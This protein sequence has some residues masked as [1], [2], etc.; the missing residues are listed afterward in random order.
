MAAFGARNR[1][2]EATLSDRKA[3][4]TACRY[5]KAAFGAPKPETRAEAGMPQRNA[6][7]PIFGLD[8]STHTL[9]SVAKRVASS[10][11]VPRESHGQRLDTDRDVLYTLV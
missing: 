1:A 11:D 3:A 7:D 8:R 5:A 10:V 2:G 4:L 9:R 6:I